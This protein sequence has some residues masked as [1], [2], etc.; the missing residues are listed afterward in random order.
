M[1]ETI[2][3]M[4]FTFSGGNALLLA[5]FAAFL[6]LAV[7]RGRKSEKMA[8]EAR[9]REQALLKDNEMLDKLN[10]MK[11]EF[12]QNMSHDFKTPLTVISTSLHNVA[13]MID[14]GDMDKA[15]MTDSLATA[16]REIM[17]LARMV[18]SAMKLS[19]LHESR[20]DM[21]RIDTVKFLH[22]VADIYR[23]LLERRN[24]VIIVDVPATL[25]YIYGNMDMLTHV[26]A[27]LLS[28]ANR[29]TLN[30]EIIIKAELDGD[31]I[32]VKTRD[33]GSGIKPEMLPNVFERGVSESGTGLG[34]SICKIAVEE[35]HKGKI[36]IASE[37]GK[38]T[39][40]TIVLPI[41]S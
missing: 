10:H 16:Q 23:V 14:Y 21:E 39:E 29:Y 38:G 37:L 9:L 18:D 17:R 11:L 2:R 36:T 31:R 30:G 41:N 40:V 25:P 15:E 24:N 7:Y 34:L 32:V 6:L 22:E 3:D 1:F 28:N 19:N 12:F 5:V 13:D 20:Q 4:G 27:N 8:S 26:M 33:S 35:V